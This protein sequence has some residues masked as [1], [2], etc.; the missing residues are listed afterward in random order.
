MFMNSFFKSDHQYL[1][2]VNIIAFKKKKK[3]TQFLR[4]YKPLLS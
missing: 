1:Q 4:K 3:K 2:W